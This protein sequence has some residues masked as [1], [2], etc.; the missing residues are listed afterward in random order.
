[1]CAS[2]VSLFLCRLLVYWSVC[3]CRVA[4][5]CAV[6]VVLCVCVCVWVQKYCSSACFAASRHLRR[7][8][9]GGPRPIHLVLPPQC[10]VA[11][12]TP[13]PEF[14]PNFSVA[15]SLT[16]TRM[17]TYLPPSLCLSVHLCLSLSLSLSVSPVQP[18]EI[19]AETPPH[20]ST[21]AAKGTPAL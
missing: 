16:H 18:T 19:A 14:A 20:I 6:V 8:I 2:S 7:Q 11:S 17:H 12:L 21:T 1:M 13:R 4:W 5:C 3:N 10:V 9:T 15:D